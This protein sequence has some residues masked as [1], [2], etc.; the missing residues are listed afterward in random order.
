MLFAYFRPPIP[1]TELARRTVADTFED[2][3]PGLAAQLAFY[4]LLALFPTLLFLVSLLAYVPA[5]TTLRELVG[6]MEA[7]LP[8][9]ILTLVR[10]QLDQVLAGDH[11]G[12]LTL[13]IAGAVWSSSSAITAIITALNRAFDV[14]EWR[15]FWKRRLMSVALTIGL[16]AFVV[17]AFTLVVGGADLGEWVARQWGMGDWFARGW[18]LAQWPVT[19]ALVV[20]AVDLVYYFAPN[21]NARWVWVTPGALLATTLWL[22]TSFGFKIYVQNFSTYSAVQ[23]AIGAVIVLMLWF[24]LSGFALL[25][26]AELDA[27]IYRAYREQRSNTEVQHEGPER[28]ARGS[29]TTSRREVPAHE[30]ARRS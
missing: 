22:V 21:T 9:E 12:L 15:P 25:I 30:R 8:A 10:M 18:A 1:W 29:E 7:I 19:L 13:G 6:R 27:E 28:G 4:F 17:S 3:C 24:Y 14:T 20:F 11:G 2:G 16:A 23:G 26:G 5:G